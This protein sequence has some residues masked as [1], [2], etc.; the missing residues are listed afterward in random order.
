MSHYRLKTTYEVEGAYG[1]RDKRTL[2]SHHNLGCD[3][4][5]FYDEDGTFLFC[6][7]DTEDNNL[8]DAITRLFAPWT[9]DKEKNEWKLNEGIEHM[10]PEE[11]KKIGQ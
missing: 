11:F 1:S 2:Y 6:V 10:T 3:V 9:H 5:S 7:E 8:M 4:V